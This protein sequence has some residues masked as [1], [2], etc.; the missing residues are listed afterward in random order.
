MRASSSKLNDVHGAALAIAV[1]NFMRPD[2]RTPVI[3]TSGHLDL[4]RKD[5]Y[6]QTVDMIFGDYC[7]VAADHL[8]ETA[9]FWEARRLYDTLSSSGA[10]NRA[11]AKQRTAAE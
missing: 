10:L 1:L 3:P 5:G 9:V 8:E 2:L 7:P 6:D 11:L 4:T